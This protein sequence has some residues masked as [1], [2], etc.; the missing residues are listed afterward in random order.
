MDLFQSIILGLLQGITEFLPVS[1]SGHLVLCQQWLGLADVEAN[2]T[3]AVLLHAASAL[4]VIAVVYREIWHI[5]TEQRK[6]ILCLVIGTV[7][8]VM[9]GMLAESA[10]ETVFLR[11]VGY[12]GLALMVTGVILLLTRRWRHGL[13]RLAETRM[14]DALV[15]GLAQAAAIV[16]GL[17]RSGLTIS[18]GMARGLDREASARFSFLLALPII[19]GATAYELLKQRGQLG[20]F[21][22]LPLAPMLAGWFV[23]LIASYGALRLLLAIV[24]RSDLRWFAAWCLPLGALVVAWSIFG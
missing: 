5:L 6:L 23:C 10:V 3:F 8:G 19:L 14:S 1:S 21:S 2:W 13:R 15:I 17:S 4:A 22:Q 11:R 12:I 20:T 18:A 16:P 7:P 24:R 9:A